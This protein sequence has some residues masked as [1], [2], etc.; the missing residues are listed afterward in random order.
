MKDLVKNP[1]GYRVLSCDLKNNYQP[2]YTRIT[3]VH[4]INP[5]QLGL[6][7]YKITTANGR[8]IKATQDHPF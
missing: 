8:T 3:Q 4:T 7:S 2:Y 1:D 6:K 5:K